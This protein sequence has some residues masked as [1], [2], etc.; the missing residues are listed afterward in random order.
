[1]VRARDVP[2]LVDAV[3]GMETPTESRGEQHP[4]SIVA[5]GNG[6]G[7]TVPIV[8]RVGPVDRLMVEAQ[9]GLVWNDARPQPASG[10]LLRRADL[11]LAEH[12]FARVVDWS[13]HVHP[14]PL[15]T[16]TVSR[17]A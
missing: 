4:V 12:G 7:N 15:A 3:F 16:A 2:R 5:A 8:V 10:E 17:S 6:W 14:H 11:A 9:L 13:P 1:M